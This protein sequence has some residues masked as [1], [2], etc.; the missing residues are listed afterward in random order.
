[1]AT[2]KK[3]DIG[4]DVS[5]QLN[6]SNYLP[7]D[8]LCKEIEKITSELDTPSITDV[9]REIE[10]VYQELEEL[11]EEIAKFCIKEKPSNI[12]QADIVKDMCQY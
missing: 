6:L 5:V 12:A 10:E 9:N 3:Y 7:T 1:M 11:G 4:E 2:F 8:H